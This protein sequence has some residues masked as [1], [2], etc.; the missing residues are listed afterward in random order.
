M[1]PLGKDIVNVVVDARKKS[2]WGKFDNIP[3]EGWDL[4]PN[5]SGGHESAFV[6]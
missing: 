2:E 6:Y 3:E 4:T 5:H 1:E